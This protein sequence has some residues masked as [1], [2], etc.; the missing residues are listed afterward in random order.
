[1][2]AATVVLCMIV[3]VIVMQNISAAPTTELQDNNA[4]DNS[5]RKY[6]LLDENGRF[7]GDI[8]ISEELIREYYNL[9]SFSS[10]PG[11]ENDNKLEDEDSGDD[12]ME[13][14]DSKKKIRK[15]AATSR[16][17]LL[18]PNARVPYQFASQVGTDQRHTIRD[19]M[20]HWED[21]TCLQFTRRSTERAYVEYSNRDTGCFSRGIGRVGRN[22]TI[23]LQTGVC[24]F[25]TVVHE[26][27]H[28]VGFWH[29]QS[30]PD[31]DN[32][33]RI[34]LDNIMPL[35]RHNF[36]R[37]RND[38]NSLGSVYDYGS[39]MHYPIN[40][41]S[42]CSGCQ[43]IQVT[44]DAAYHAQGR[45]TLGQRNGLSTRDVQQANRLYSCPNRGVLGL[46]VVHIRNGRSLPD[47]D[48]IWNAPDPYV[49]IT[50]V[51]SSG[52]HH[53][54]TT[55]VQ[56]GTTSPNWDERFQFPESIFIE[57]QFFR[58]QIWND[59]DTRDYKMSVSETIV[60]T[61]G[62]HN[63]RHCSDSTCHGYVSYG[64]T[65]TQ[66]IAATLTVTVRYARNL[67]DT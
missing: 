38:V 17:N 42:Q 24:P 2:T 29:E 39:V 66:G 51:D 33:V 56:Q 36:E 40:A 50:A 25:G 27:G 49:R 15:R 57:W 55:A 14:S 61:A 34:N 41:F 10:L 9:S 35:R 18:W 12:L 54:R 30:R 23:N 11:S 67:D 53:V 63:A 58:I 59:D 52:R 37:R 64:Y 28:A 45:P 32:Y 43:T 7:E 62:Q 31:R 47:T 6:S 5:T 8:V 16:R 4:G 48:P 19:A 22:Q 44:N 65:M 20:D 3:N 46:L 60:V 26:I 1:M 21:R 13:V